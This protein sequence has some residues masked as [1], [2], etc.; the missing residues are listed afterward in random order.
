MKYLAIYTIIPLMLFSGCRSKKTIADAAYAISNEQS[1]IQADPKLKYYDQATWL[2][3]YFSVNRLLQAPYSEWYIQ[4]YDDYQPQ[5]EF[6]D[7]LRG[8]DYKDISILIVLGTWCPDS[9][10]EVP[11]FM[12]ITDVIGFPRDH[13]E[14]VGVDNVKI[15]PIENYDAL[16]I[17]RVPTFI[18]YRNKV[19]TGR[20]IETPAT[21]LEQD[22]LNILTRNEKQ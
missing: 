17:E 16:G 2:L 12:R 15:S 5:S 20:I 8:L 7:K 22:M 11:R 4:E 19:E 6:T 13:L 10:R 3:G 9:R 1:S 21:S 18:F 14:F